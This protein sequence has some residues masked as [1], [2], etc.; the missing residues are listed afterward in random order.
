M[1]EKHHCLNPNDYLPKDQLP[2]REPWDRWRINK[3]FLQSLKDRFGRRVFT[4]A[5]A[6]HIYGV[7][8]ARRDGRGRLDLNW[9]QFGEMNVRNHLCAAAYRGLL[10]RL[11]RG[12]Y[13][14][15]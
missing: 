13:K 7:F 11:G 2:N 10:K 4:N 14:F 5:E 8:H 6:Y 3:R 12:K 15:K 9:R 1:T